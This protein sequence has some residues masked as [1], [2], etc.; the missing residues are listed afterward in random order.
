MTVGMS[1][2]WA[3]TAGAQTGQGAGR[4]SSRG[5][6]IL[7]S[8]G[9]TQ[10]DGNA[11]GYQR[12][13]LPP[14]DAEGPDMVRLGFFRLVPRRDLYRPY[15]D[16]MARRRTPIPSSDQLP[17][18]VIPIH[19]PPRRQPAPVQIP[20]ADTRPLAVIPLGSFGSARPQ[21]PAMPQTP[22]QMGQPWNLS[23]FR[24]PTKGSE[25]A[26]DERKPRRSV[27]SAP[28]HC[29]PSCGIQ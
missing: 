11:R 6:V 19:V 27:P 29:D 12:P 2:A 17:Q 8:F 14:D 28:R 1:L 7:P 3:V 15:F 22:Y 16:E 24:T 10:T 9:A 20:S 18:A 5:P 25:D 26:E 21:P 23:P 4:G 13:Y